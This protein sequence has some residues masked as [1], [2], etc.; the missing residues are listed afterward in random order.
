MNYLVTTSTQSAFTQV[1]NYTQFDLQL[2]GLPI[3]IVGRSVTKGSIGCL[4]Q[5]MVQPMLEHRKHHL[6]W[7]GS[8]ILG[9]HWI[10]GYKG[11]N[12]RVPPKTREHNICFRG[13]NNRFYLLNM[14]FACYACCNK[15]WNSNYIFN[16]PNIFK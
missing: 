3:L 14:H 16:F 9:R 10:G 15:I 7:S 12:I 13:R 5:P 1:V 2:C 6:I 4:V 11:G 8:S